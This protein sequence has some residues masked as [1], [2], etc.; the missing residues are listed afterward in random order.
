[1]V[2]ATGS[3]ES[4]VFDAT[5]LA[6]PSVAALR[7][8]VVIAPFEPELRPRT[9][10]RPGF[11]SCWPAGSQ[12]TATCLSAVGGPDRPL[13]AADVLAKAA[14]L[15]TATR[16]ALPLLQGGSRTVP[17]ASISAGRVAGSDDYQPSL[18]QEIASRAAAA[19]GAVPAAVDRMARL[20]LLD[21]LA[22]LGRLAPPAVRSAA[23]RAWW[24]AH[25]P[26]GPCSVLGLDREVPAV[27][28][29][30]VN[31]GF[32]HSL[33]YD[34]THVASVMH[35]SSL[36]GPARWPWPRRPAAAGPMRSVPTP[37]GGRS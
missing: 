3:T 10:A 34:D 28:A 32:I 24:P 6:D 8:R 7:Q 31:G 2:L 27:V 30:L 33:E 12:Q 37:S 13:A 15:T 11:R 19:L 18:S 16:P 4:G 20:H 21:A 35:G 26:A 23:W 9:I 36:A 29:A 14:R 1:M 5:R 22:D 25:A 17:L